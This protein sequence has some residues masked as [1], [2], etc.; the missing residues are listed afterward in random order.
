MYGATYTDSKKD[1]HYNMYET[2][3]LIEKKNE[4][5]CNQCCNDVGYASLNKMDE[6]YRSGKYLRELYPCRCRS[7][8]CEGAIAGLFWGAV[9]TSV[10][11]IPGAVLWGLPTATS[12]MVAGGQALVGTASCITGC[13]S[14]CSVPRT[15]LENCMNV[16]TDCC[17]EA[18]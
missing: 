2:N 4:S 5:D 6:A 3:A 1:Y 14:L 9:A 8:V 7:L 10:C 16:D 15:M 12:S 17:Y 18:Y 11:W 13:A